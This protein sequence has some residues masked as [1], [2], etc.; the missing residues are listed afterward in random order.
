MRFAFL[1]C[2]CP[3]TFVLKEQINSFKTIISMLRSYAEVDVYIFLKLKD[4]DDSPYTNLIKSEEGLKNLDDFLTFAMPKCFKLQYKF[5]YES[6]SRFERNNMF[7][8]QMKRIDDM[9][10]EAY[11]KYDY[12][13]YI[14]P[15]CILTNIPTN[16]EEL[17][18]NIVYTSTRWDCPGN[19]HM[20][21]MS[22]ITINNW[23]IDKVRVLIEYYKEAKV[24]ETPEF[25]IFKDINPV[26]IFKSGL[27]RVYKQID[28]WTFAHALIDIVDFWNYPESYAKL[29]IS[30]EDSLF[31]KG[32]DTLI[33][34]HNGIVT[35]DLKEVMSKYLIETLFS[36]SVERP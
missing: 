23:W 29:L 10:I 24:P 25:I 14:R 16:F 13:L 34:K 2:G 36:R 18:K 3:R 33:K 19:D 31:Y 6:D 8:S 32:L 22:N 26:Q 15:D 1:I 5:P 11:D 9:I 30:L 27:I 21:V 20:F 17:D 12:Y 35:D 28:S 7:H 4:K